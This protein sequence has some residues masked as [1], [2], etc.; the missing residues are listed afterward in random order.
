MPLQSGAGRCATCGHGA[1]WHRRMTY[2]PASAAWYSTQQT[3]LRQICPV[4]Q[5]GDAQWQQQRQ[6]W[7]QPKPKP[8][9]VE[10]VTPA[11]ECCYNAWQA[12]AAEGGRRRGAHAWDE[13][14]TLTN[15]QPTRQL[16]GGEVTDGHTFFHCNTSHPGCPWTAHWSETN[17]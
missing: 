9:P 4:A 1:A 17:R 3:P 6:Q 14:N 15:G 2:G 11:A 12:P 13:P 10:L 16:M 8:A 5:S 7:L